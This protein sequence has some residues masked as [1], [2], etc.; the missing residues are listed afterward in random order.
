MKR[1]TL[2]NKD[3]LRKMLRNYLRLRENN[4]HNGKKLMMNKL[5]L[6]VPKEL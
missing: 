4:A 6:E 2:E 5:L 1:N 3:K